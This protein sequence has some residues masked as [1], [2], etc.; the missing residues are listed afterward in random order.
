MR[1][2]EKVTKRMNSSTRRQ[3]LAGAAA[4]FTGFAGCNSSPSSGDTTPTPSRRR[5]DPPV[6]I[7]RNTTNEMI[8]R[9]SS[10]GTSGEDEA[11]G[12]SGTGSGL[13]V[14]PSD[15]A[16]LSFTAIDGIDNAKRFIRNTDFSTE[17]IIYQQVDIEECYTLDLCSVSWS[18]TEYEIEFGQSLR[19]AN[20]SCAADTMVKA[21][22]FIRIPTALNPDQITGSSTSTG[23]QCESQTL[24][25]PRTNRSSEPQTANTGSSMTEQSRTSMN[26]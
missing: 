10:S 25:N 6:V 11:D 24:P 15:M 20:A 13:I 12:I 3:V 7:V 18:S 2:A 26:K 1:S 4:L 9:S 21:A 23:G 5:T 17:T 19:P 14:S 22:A 8:I 16:D